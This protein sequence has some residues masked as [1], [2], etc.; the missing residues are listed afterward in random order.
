MPRIYPKTKYLQKFGTPEESE[1]ARSNFYHEPWISAASNGKV[2]YNVDTS[3]WLKQYLTFKILSSGVI[4]WKSKS[5]PKTI[6]YRINGGNWTSLTSTASG[7]TFSVSVGD[8][9]EFRGNNEGYATSQSAYSYFNG[10]TA[11]FIAK[12]NIMSLINSEDFENSTSLVGWAF[13]CLFY[14]CSTLVDAYQLLL[15]A[16]E[17]TTSSTMTTAQ[18]AYRMMF[19]DCSNLERGP[20]E[21]PVLTLKGAS[22]EMMFY[23]CSKLIQAPEIKAT[24]VGGYSLGHMFYHCSSLLAPPPYIIADNNN[25]GYGMK[26]M[27]Q[28][29]TSLTYSPYID[30]QNPGIQF[31]NQTFNGC[32]SLKKITCVITKLN[33]SDEFHS[34]VS[35][36]P[37][38]GEFIKHPSANWSRGNNGIPTGWTVTDADI[39]QS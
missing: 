34:W 9:V 10:T 15:P 25:Q 33:A 17:F 4:C 19:Q 23:G 18:A 22:Y 28:G 7:A 35:G 37:S 11:R 13:S 8:T 14:G 16:T 36:V 39:P 38:T 21:L 2:L 29:C 6:E 30:I 12:G 31:F 26:C 20:M 1:E 32:S 3:K 27:F 5:L 24:F